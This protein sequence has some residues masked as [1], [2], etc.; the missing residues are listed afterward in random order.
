MGTWEPHEMQTNLS[1]L[2]ARAADWEGG[3]VLFAVNEHGLRIG[4]DHPRAKLTDHDVEQIRRLAEGGM[5]YKHI[6]VKFEISRWTVG[7]ICRYERRAQYADRF[8][9]YE[10]R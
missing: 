4:E 7:R 10:D 6:A 1:I 5:Q 9:Q 2:P 8:K 3:M